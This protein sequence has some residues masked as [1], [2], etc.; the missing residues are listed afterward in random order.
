MS[1]D[2]TPRIDK[3]AG[4]LHAWLRF[5]RLVQHGRIMTLTRVGWLRPAWP[6]PGAERGW[7]IGL[8]RRCGATQRV[9]HA[10]DRA[11]VLRTELLGLARPPLI[12][13]R[14]RADVVFVAA[15]AVVRASVVRRVAVVAGDISAGAQRSVCRRARS[16]HSAIRVDAAVA[17]QTDVA[18]VRIGAPVTRADLTH[19][20]VGVRLTRV[21]SAYAHSAP[22]I[23]AAVDAVVVR[24]A[25]EG[26]VPHEA[27]RA[28]SPGSDFREVKA[29]FACM[30]ELCHGETIELSADELERGAGCV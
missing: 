26:A 2:V 18:A 17:W 27:R 16:A 1:R 9:R 4:N 25:C 11:K 13:G 21:V 24:R 10:A 5:L 30:V 28:G 6:R 7:V 20:A 8:S 15:I 29:P 3:V 23:G 19:P 12:G 22:P 14:P